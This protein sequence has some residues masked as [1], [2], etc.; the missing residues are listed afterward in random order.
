MRAHRHSLRI[1]NR[2]EHFKQ[3]E[4]ACKNFESEAQAVVASPQISGERT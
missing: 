2:R 4:A 3:A 1:A